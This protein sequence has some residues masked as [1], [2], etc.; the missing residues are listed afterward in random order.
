MPI[1]LLILPGY[2]WSSHHAYVGALMQPWVTTDFALRM[3]H[4]GRGR[5]IAAY[6]RFVAQS[7]DKSTNSPLCEYNPHDR[8]ILGNDVF[9]SKLLNA[10]WQPKIAQDAQ[11]SHH[12]SLPVALCHR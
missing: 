6:Q 10:V 12:R 4:P 2:P 11:R 3:F 5:A 9:A 7:L 1:W 8:R